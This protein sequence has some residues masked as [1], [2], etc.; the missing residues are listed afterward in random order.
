MSKKLAVALAVLMLAIVAWGL[1]LERNA[2]TIVINGQQ[3]TGP[4]KDS[5]GAGG[6]VVALIALF[7]AATLL[8]FVFAGIGLLV[9]GCLV[10]LGLILAGLAFPFLLPVLI[11][12]AILWGFVALTRNP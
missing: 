6:L 1:F 12:L 10:V 9:L 3:V 4:L 5:I 2:V 11:P 8:V 7:C